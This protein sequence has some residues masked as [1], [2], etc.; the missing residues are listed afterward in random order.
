MLGLKG[1]ETTLT[2]TFTGSKKVQGIPNLTHL[3]H[4]VERGPSA[5]RILRLRQPSQ[6][7]SETARGFCISSVSGIGLADVVAIAVH[8]FSCL[9]IFNQLRWHL[10]HAEEQLPLPALKCCSL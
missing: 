8:G 5:Q 4:G 10:Q 3:R 2:L 9:G 7:R 6:A 1:V